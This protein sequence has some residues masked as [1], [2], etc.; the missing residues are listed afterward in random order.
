MPKVM[1]GDPLAVRLFARIVVSPSGCWL[2]GPAIE[3]GWYGKIWDGERAANTH[4]IVWSWLRGPVPEGRELDHLCRNRPCCNPDHMEPVTHKEN[5][6]RGLLPIIG[7]LRRFTQTHCKRGH[8][9]NS[10]NT[11]FEKKQRVCLICKRERDRM[12][13]VGR[14]A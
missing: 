8:E 10:E 1:Y 5:C 14:A 2:F 9:F 4:A 6:M 3:K 13:P 11:R 7:R 12:Y